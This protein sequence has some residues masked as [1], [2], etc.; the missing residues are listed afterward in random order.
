MKTRAAYFIIGLLFVSLSSAFAAVPQAVPVDLGLAGNFA[1]LTKTG[2][3]TVP[4]SSITG[5][6][7]VSPIAATAITGFTLT[8]DASNEYS[9]STQVTGKIFAADYGAPTP[10]ILT[11]AISNMEAAYTDASGRNPD[12]IELYT[13]DLSG[14]TVTPGVYKWGTGV[15][16]NSDVTLHGGPSDVFI[17]QIA[18]TLVVANGVKVVLTGGARAR[19]I[20]WQVS[21]EV[22][23]GTGAH[24]EGIILGKTKICLGTKASVNGRLLAQTAVTLIQNSIVGP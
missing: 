21:E 24:F 8:A 18:K 13:G 23:I 19:N 6:L 16:V 15:S 14:K 1:I 12:Y 22:A 11:T 17:F 10:S 2:V 5:D 3:S 9:F 7:G 20:F 4:A